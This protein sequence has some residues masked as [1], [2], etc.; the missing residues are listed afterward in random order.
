MQD[1]NGQDSDYLVP[2]TW[3]PA[4]ESVRRRG[5]NTEHRRPSRKTRTSGLHHA[6]PVCGFFEGRYPAPEPVRRRGPDTE[7]RGPSRKTRTSGMHP[8]P[9]SIRALRAIHPSPT[10]LRPFITSSLHYSVTSSPRRSVP[11]LSCTF[12]DPLPRGQLQFFALSGRV[13]G[14]WGPS[15]SSLDS[16]WTPTRPRI[17][18]EV[19]RGK[20][21]E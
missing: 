20:S 17:G 18:T 13:G 9:A 10:L 8:D 4:P 14:T 15:G 11:A 2:G 16:G 12:L 1:R 21:D 3:Y 7:H 19:A 6:Y 5:P